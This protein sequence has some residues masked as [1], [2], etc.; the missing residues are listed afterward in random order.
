MFSKFYFF[1]K[2]IQQ[3]GRTNIGL[4]EWSI[5]SSWSEACSFKSTKSYIAGITSLCLFLFP[6]CILDLMG[7]CI[8]RNFKWIWFPKLLVGSVQFS[9]LVHSMQPLSLLLVCKT[10]LNLSSVN[11]WFYSDN[12]SWRSVNMIVISMVYPFVS[13]RCF[14]PWPLHRYIILLYCYTMLSWT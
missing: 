10:G 13:T 4:W 7:C 2:D 5:T 9:S 11:I 1:M 12:E 6:T 8:S 14:G 3:H